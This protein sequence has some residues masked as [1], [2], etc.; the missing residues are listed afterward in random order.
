MDKRKHWREQEQQL[1]EKW[2][3]AAQ[4]YRDIMAQIARE[5]PFAGTAGPSEDIMSKAQAVRAE[6]DALRKK[7]ARLKSEFNSG[8][9]Y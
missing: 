5:D 6:I 2:N 3:S 9:R 8:K 4:R 7:V 1:I